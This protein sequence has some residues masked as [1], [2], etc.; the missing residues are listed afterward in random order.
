MPTA[1]G[2][3]L[4]SPPTSLTT[5]VWRRDRVATRRPA[6][7]NW[8]AASKLLADFISRSAAYLHQRGRTVLFWGEYPL[9]PEDIGALPS[10]LVNGEMAG[11]EFDP[12]FKAHGIRQLIYTSTQGEEPLFPNYHPL[13]AAERLHARVPGRGARPSG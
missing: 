2:S 1:A 5:S 10:Y 3:T 7:A 12:V 8:A 9:K 13:P 11:P 4:F 6:R